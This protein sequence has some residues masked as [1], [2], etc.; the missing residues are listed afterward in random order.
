MEKIKELIEQF[1]NSWCPIVDGWYDAREQEV[2]K[3]E[4][5]E[6]L[7]ETNR[8]AYLVGYADHH[9]H[10]EHQQFEN[11]WKQLI[12]QLTKNKKL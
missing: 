1:S 10:P 6:L 4:L 9:L 5:M 3:S 7:E 2:M 12:D 8:V 11:Y